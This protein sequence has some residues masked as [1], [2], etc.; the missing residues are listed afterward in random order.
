KIPRLGPTTHGTTH[1]TTTRPAMRIA[2]P[3]LMAGV[4]ALLSACGQGDSDDVL[5]PLACHSGAWR[6]GDGTTFVLTPT[7]DGGM[8]YRL[9]DGRSGR[10]ST[11][12]GNAEATAFEGWR[13][14]GPVAARATFGECGADELAFSLEG[15]PEGTA[16]RLP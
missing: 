16:R 3:A 11:Q 15:G 10:L 14:D 5:S 12:P 9:V 1:M 6:S 4:M 7:S 13:D 8:R 2:L